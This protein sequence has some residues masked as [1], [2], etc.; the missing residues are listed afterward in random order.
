MKNIILG[1][2]ITSFL[3][4]LAFSF[5]ATGS[6]YVYEYWSSLYFPRSTYPSRGLFRNAQ[7][8]DQAT[9]VF[10]ILAL[11]FGFLTVTTSIF[12]RTCFYTT[13]TMVTLSFLIQTVFS[14]LATGYWY[15]KDDYTSWLKTDSWQFAF[16]WTS[17]GLYFVAFLHVLISRWRNPIRKIVNQ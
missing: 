11:C 1:A 3:T 13:V 6:Y 14:G 15:E 17:V 16:I 2:K 12:R 4:F 10:C 5:H 7:S 9:S 8:C